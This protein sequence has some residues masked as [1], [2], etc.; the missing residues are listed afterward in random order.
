ML[1]FVKT[2]LLVDCTGMVMSITIETRVIDAIK[3]IYYVFYYRNIIVSYNEH[4]YLFM[5]IV[6][7]K[8][9]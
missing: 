6:V 2:I 8:V 7:L 4:R 3:T 9:N 1:R 5:A